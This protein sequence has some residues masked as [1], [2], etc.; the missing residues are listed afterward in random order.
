MCCCWVARPSTASQTA[1][2]TW[3]VVTGGLQGALGGP[4]RAGG[5]LQAPWEAPQQCAPC[6]WPRQAPAAGGRIPVAIGSFR[7][8]SVRTQGPRLSIQKHRRRRRRLPP[9]P[10]HCRV[11]CLSR[12]AIV[13]NR[14]GGIKDEVYE[15][16]THLMV[17]WFERPII[18]DVRLPATAAHG[19][20]ANRFRPP[21]GRLAAWLCQNLWSS[22]VK[23][24]SMCLAV[25]AAAARC[26]S[27]PS[28][29]PPRNGGCRRRLASPSCCLVRP[30]SDPTA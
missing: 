27:A 4:I 7:R 9:L 29:C 17:P 23:R 15:E 16:G 22:R 30:P 12:R 13:F 1:S 11:S 28:C 14:L 18:Y 6:R 21:P 24:P 19:R 25:P 8:A 5:A 20:F 10:P 3:R 26:A 2:S